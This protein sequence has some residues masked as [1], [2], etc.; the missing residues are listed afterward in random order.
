MPKTGECVC[1]A[2]FKQKKSSTDCFIESLFGKCF[3][4]RYCSAGGLTDCDAQ[5]PIKELCD[6]ED[7]DCDTKVDE[8]SDIC[9]GGK[10]CKCVGASCGCTCAEPFVDCGDGKC[11]DLNSSV[12]HCSAC[13]KPCEAPNVETYACQGG[14]CKIVKCKAGFENVDGDYATGCECA[15]KPEICD[16]VDNDCDG[17]VDEGEEA[18]PGTEGCQGTCVDGV[19]QCPAGCSWCDSMCVKDP[20]AF[21]F[22]PDH[23]GSCDNKCSLP[24]VKVH[25]CDMGVCLPLECEQGWSNCNETAF[26]GCEWAVVQEAC[27]CV[28]DDCDGETDELPLSDC[29]AP[30]VCQG[31]FCQCPKDNP[32]VMD[33]GETGCK[34]ISNDPANCGWCGNDCAALALPGVK[35]YGCQAK[36][37]IIVGCEPNL[38]DTNKITWDGCEC[39]KTSAGE[40]CDTIDNN[41]D[42]QIDEAPLTDCKEPKV[43]TG[44]FCSCPLDKPNL[45]E[46]VPDKCMDILTDSKHCG[47]CGNDCAA[48]AWDHVSV[49]D[50]V[51]GMC[52]IKSCTPPFVDVNA[53][54]YDGCECEKTAATE[55][56]D[57]I[58]NN[59]DGQTDEVPNN[60]ILPKVCQWGDCICPPDQPNL[61]D[62][63]TGKCTDTNTDVNNCGFC[64]N[65]CDLLNVG[66]QKCEGGQCVVAAC[67]PGFKDCDAIAATGCEFE[68]KIE[69]CNGFDDDCDKE[70]DE[71]AQGIGQPC[72]S[73]IPG[74]CSKGVQICEN[75]SLKCKPNIA[76]GQ[77]PE[78]CD[79]KDNNCDGGI[80][81]GNPGGGG[82][83]TV[84]GLQGEC[85]F[86]ALEC[87]N[88]NLT[89]KQTYFPQPEE[90]D[91]K[92]NEC[93]GIIDGME[94]DCF[95]M[96]GNGKEKCTNGVWGVCSAQAPKL[97]KNWQSCQM[98]D[99]CVQ[100]CPTAPQEQC[101]GMDENCDG[102][103]DETFACT[104]GQMKEQKCGNC[105]NQSSTCTGQCSWGPWSDCGG[106]G[107]CS[108]GQSKIEGSCGNCGQQKWSC[109]SY[110]S[111]QQDQCINQ[112]T[113]SP[114][115]SKNE[116]SCGKCGQYQY[117]CNNSCQWQ[118]GACTNEGICSPGQ[119]KNE[120]SCGNCGTQAW[121]CNG[122]CQWSKTTCNNQGVCSPNSTKKEGSCGNCGK[123][124]Y[125]C[126]GSCTWSQGGCTDQGACTPGATQW[127]S[128]CQR[129][130]CSGSCQW[131]NCANYCGGDKTASGCYCDALCPGAGDCCPDDGPSG[132]CE[133]CGT[134][135]NSCEPT[136][137]NGDGGSCY[138]DSDCITFHDCC[139]NARSTCG[140]QTC[141]NGCGQD[142]GSGC[143]CDWNCGW[144]TQ[145]PC[146]G[147]KT[148]LCP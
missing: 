47:G 135:C 103:I 122:S 113:C 138:C 31:C 84:Q 94:K 140:T 49:Y 16:G 62:C 25:A 51:G 21:F 106:Q 91:G 20:D 73:G 81:E 72:E 65:K 100:V 53:M 12:E 46:C 131:G 93:D 54:P 145:G 57:T 43:C 101:N 92:D 115:S 4:E 74:L 19:C 90:C 102:K 88:A 78:V 29:Q 75:G 3:G 111:W 48:M 120:G 34:N 13:N 28:D 37:C 137:C 87:T 5:D 136:E 66:F 95:T 98:E 39:N 44:G 141:K 147:D 104:I 6:G 10:E 70:I 109:N 148:Y 59:C 33:C 69:E 128:G 56:C 52:A 22:D 11:V 2:L 132:A 121:S 36:E 30:K 116:G 1:S 40:L 117:S 32:D 139:N 35:Q 142:F 127:C 129:K 77:F 18:C 45:M 24:K 63:G 60:C 130:T 133:T 9:S 50:C 38:F 144:P 80:D 124:L 58:D 96:C 105:G 83:C 17:A 110:C 97:C 68:V 71:G 108:P 27:N 143:D 61:Q 119:T 14:K 67:K 126:T 107:Q 112:G 79:G 125:T 118:Q 123:Y 42:G 85:K 23:C 146:C 114:G 99:M 8:D 64:G 76:P 89:C 41:C 26:D 82:P 15:I 55:V 7:N 86:G 134:G